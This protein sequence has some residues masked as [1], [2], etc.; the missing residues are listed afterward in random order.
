M[1]IFFAKLILQKKPTNFK[2]RKAAYNTFLQKKPAHK[3][4]MKLIMCLPKIVILINHGM[5]VNKVGATEYISV[6]GANK[7]EF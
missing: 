7:I 2:H 6:V 4:L 5:N 3:M 1:R